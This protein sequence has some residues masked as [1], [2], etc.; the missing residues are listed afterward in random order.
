[1]IGG[2]VLDS[3]TVL[4]FARQDSV[5]GGALVWTAV[6]EDIVLLV[7][8]TSAM[9]AWAGLDEP[10]HPALEVLLDLPVIVCARGTGGGRRSPASPRPAQACNCRWRSSPRDARPPR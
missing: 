3:S 2:R 4:T 8:S 9:L 1:M 7:P 10:D 6:E 5:D